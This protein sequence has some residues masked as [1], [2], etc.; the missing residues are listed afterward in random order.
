MKKTLSAIIVILLGLAILL[1]PEFLENIIGDCF[2]GS[3]L[4]IFAFLVIVVPI[5]IA[6]E[7]VFTKFMS[8]IFQNESYQKELIKSLEKSKNKRKNKT[9]IFGIKCYSCNQ[10]SLI[11]SQD[12]VKFGM[13][14]RQCS[15]CGSI[16]IIRQP[17]YCGV[18]PVLSILFQKAGVFTS[19]EQFNLSFMIALIITVVLLIIHFLT[20]AKPLND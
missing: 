1:F 16:N 7:K 12:S 19:L 8:L 20:P 3:S 17:A 14:A 9:N 6:F 18:P 5:S 15:E 13:F 4:V 11:I 2:E 10:K